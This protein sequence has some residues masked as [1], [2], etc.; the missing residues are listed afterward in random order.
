MDYRGSRK[1]GQLDP[2]RL[3]AGTVLF[4][5]SPAGDPKDPA[6]RPSR[7][8]AT[9]GG[10]RYYRRDHRFRLRLRDHIRPAS[11]VPLY[12]GL[13]PWRGQGAANASTYQE[14][15]AHAYQSNTDL[16]VPHAAS[17]WTRMA[18][19]SWSAHL[20]GPFVLAVRRAARPLLYPRVLSTDLLASRISARWPDAAGK[21][22]LRWRWLRSALPT[23][24]SV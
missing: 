7:G 14:M 22:D 20:R 10:A 24:T 4:G 15:N 23:S 5:A 11:T 19:T 8:G 9:S 13:P 2:P 6:A 1:S 16:L 17:A 3:A 12:H 18:R 21:T